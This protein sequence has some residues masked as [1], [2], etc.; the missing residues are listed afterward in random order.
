LLSDSKPLPDL[1]SFDDGILSEI[2]G[3]EQKA[4]KFLSKDSSVKARIVPVGDMDYVFLY[5]ELSRYA[6]K[7]LTLGVYFEHAI[8]STEQVV[9]LYR[10]VYFGIAILV[11]SMIA[12]LLVAHAIGRPIVRLS[13]AAEDIRAGNLDRFEALPRTPIRELTQASLSFNGM[14]VG[15]QERNLVRG[16]L[17][18]YV[19]EGIVKKLI[20]K[21]GA[22]EP[23]ST[24]ATVLFS[25]IAGFTAISEKISPREMVDM[26]N[27]YFTVLADILEAHSGVIA[28][29]QGDGLLAMFNAP[30]AD[31]EHAANAVRSAMEI[32]T[33]VR[34][35]LFA[36]HQLSCRV[37]LATGEVVVGSVGASDRLSYTVYGDTVNLASRLE[38]MNKQCGT[39]ILL[40]ERTEELAGDFPFERIGEVEVRGKAQ[41]VTVYTVAV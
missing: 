14:V 24:E 6:D 38:Q 35:R 23:L 25:D 19:P 8:E 40:P 1:A 29:F 27:E 11:V 2:W 41:P 10:M 22:L 31:P 30:V 17:G 37:G 33:A 7:P 28:Q 18:K 16:L 15:L 4:V 32:Q 3:R 9:R 26:L 20:V 36:G 21:K 34:G 13:D 5:R 12:A 39:A